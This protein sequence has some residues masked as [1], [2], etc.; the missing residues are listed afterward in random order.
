[1]HMKN[2]YEGE[3][4]LNYKFS[5]ELEKEIWCAPVCWCAFCVNKKAM[6]LLY[7]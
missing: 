7:T 3:K 1:M 5:N 6:V 4:S 2:V